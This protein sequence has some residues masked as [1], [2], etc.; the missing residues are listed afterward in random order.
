LNKE[1]LKRLADNPDFISGIYNY[2]DRWCERCPFTSRCMNYAIS[3]EEF[4]D[5]DSM[6]VDNP[7]FNEKIFDVFKVSTELLTEM[8]E[9]HDI[10]LNDI[11]TEEYEQERKSNRE[12]AE[13]SPCSIE[14]K[15]Y[16]THV[17]EWFEF[18]ENL[19]LDKEEEL[20]NQLDFNIAGTDP[21][22]AS[23]KIKDSI[24]VILWYQHQNYVKIMRALNGKYREEKEDWDDIPKD[25]D[26][27]AKVALIGIDNSLKAWEHL[28]A[29]LTDNNDSILD[30]LILLDRLKNQ[31]EKEF[32]E[33]RNFIRPGLDE[34]E[35][36]SELRS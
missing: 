14:A 7:E 33:A 28:N 13:S 30:M 21:V 1:S 27:S 20:N 6:D 4:S 2:C 19:F 31:V 26:G 22:K 12:S 36:F 18:S 8:A 32:P 15:K 34:P 23:D 25:S 3:Q 24:E 29:Q 10:D 35:K 16:T 9:E 17:K 5:P 11:D